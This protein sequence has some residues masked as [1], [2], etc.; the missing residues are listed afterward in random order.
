MFRKENSYLIKVSNVVIC[1]E[2]KR[3]G[4]TELLLFFFFRFL[5]NLTGTLLC[6]VTL[7][8]SSH[9]P[10]SLVSTV[11]RYKKHGDFYLQFKHSSL[12]LTFYQLRSK[13]IICM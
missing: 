6:I 4:A 11:E 12:T 1:I 10:V 2:A 5:I 13:T 8:Q 7:S 3:V 9:W